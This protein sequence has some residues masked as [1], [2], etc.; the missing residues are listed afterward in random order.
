MWFEVLF[1]S[2]LAFCQKTDAHPSSPQRQKK[3]DSIRDEIIWGIFSEVHKWVLSGVF[4]PL[5]SCIWTTS[6]ASCGQLGMFLHW[7]NYRIGCVCSG[8][9]GG[10][11]RVLIRFW[12]TSQMGGIL[13]EKF[14]S[15]WNIFGAM[16]GPLT[17]CHVSSSAHVQKGLEKES[18]SSN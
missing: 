3:K 13:P 2:N 10:M 15:D 17:V 7:S 14:L 8:L 11:H 4:N 18:L 6:E 12:K 5:A 9:W 1:S 16:T